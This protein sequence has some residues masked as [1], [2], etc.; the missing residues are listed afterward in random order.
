MYNGILIKYGEIALRGGNRRLHETILAN[1]I[2]SR[3]A[4]M[5]LADVTRVRKDQ[6]RVYVEAVDG[7]V[8][9]DTKKVADDISHIFGI[10][11]VCP[12]VITDNSDFEHIKE[13]SLAL[14]K[15]AAIPGGTFKVEAS[16]AD[17]KFP[18]NSQE[19]SAQVG[20]HLLENMPELAV[21][22]IAPDVKI[23][24]EIRKKVYI[25]INQAIKGPGGL[26]AGSGGK[27]ALLLSGGFDSP[28]AG[29][30]M[31]RRGVELV[32]V[33]FHSPP[34]TSELA[35]EK[36]VDLAKRLSFYTGGI[37]LYVVNLTEAMLYLNGKVP[38]VK[39]TLFLKRAMLTAANIVA[40]KENAQALIT[41]DSVGQVASQTMHALA[42]TDSAAGLPVL[43]P[44]AAMDKL[45]ILE[46]AR[47]IGT[48][49]ISVRPHADCCTV[50]VP[51]HPELKPKKSVIEN[52]EKRLVELP[53]MLVG[54]V[55]NAEVILV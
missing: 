30:N 37:K 4:D 3:L 17:K 11:Y 25:Y 5:G 36:A 45:E 52:M 31:A 53:V 55:D 47:K 50:F 26:P 19:I 39:L 54:A 2:M 15:D 48:Y 7:G 41:G 14:M 10:T 44:L 27:A 16:R 32:C 20:A 40:E 51:K 38:E 6:G 33:Y 8:I 42:A 49:D 18:L 24:V 46:T 21:K 22:M 12:C 1:N 34:Y 35:K 28:V 23:T 29:Y 13:L 9:K 43:R